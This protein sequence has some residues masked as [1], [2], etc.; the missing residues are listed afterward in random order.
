MKLNKESERSLREHLPRVLFDEAHQQ[1]WT[2]RNDLAIE[3]NRVNPT[4]STMLKAR[5]ELERAGFSIEINK[6]SLFTKELLKKYNA[7]FFAHNSDPKYEKTTG[8]GNAKLNKD[9]LAVIEEYVRNGGG[10]LILAEHE[11][12]KYNNSMSEMLEIFNIE[13]VNTTV[14]DPERSFNKVSSWVKPDLVNAGDGVLSRVNE[15]IFYRA[16]VVKVSDDESVCVKAKS[17]KSSDPK[18]EAMLVLKKFGAGR[19]A[20]VTDSDIFGDD[21]YQDGDHVQLLLNLM[22]WLVS[23]GGSE[24]VNKANELGE[25]WLSLKEEVNRFKN[26]QEKDGSVREEN[27]SE[28]KSSLDKILELYSNFLDVHPHNKD[29]YRKTVE[30]LNKWS[31][32][33]FGKPDFLD[34]LVSFRPDLRRENGLEH[35]VLSVMYTQ[36]GNPN[37]SLEALWIRTVWPDWINELEA[38]LYNNK[39]FIPVEFLDFS[40]G[41]E[42][43]SAVLFPETVPVREVPKFHWGAIF[44]DREAA[45]F[46]KIVSEA[47]K[48]LNFEVPTQVEMLLSNKN[49]AKEVY[50]LWDLVHDRTHSHGELP[51]DPFMIKQRIPFWMYALEEM[52]CDLNTFTEMDN[53]Y[54]KGVSHASYVKYAIILD[55]VLRFP[56][57]GNR[58]KNYDGLVGQIM[59]GA[60]HKAGALLWVD[61]KLRVNWER[62]ENVIT[63]LAKEVNSLY[64]ESID[65]SRIEFWIEGYK[66]VRKYVSPHPSSSWL[67]E[68]SFNK[69]NKELTDM[70]LA[71]EFPL[72]VFYE[73]LAKKLSKSIEEC[74]GIVL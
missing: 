32:E 57:S 47:S 49:F 28:A 60:L 31:K 15:L 61:N 37:R 10:L 33:G 30:D 43:H 7:L 71:D 59:F 17:S 23:T 70:V 50:V 8:A 29:Y 66:L 67:K 19:I 11:N 46:I 18:E 54:A 45:R 65:R 20:V 26:F 24:S 16:G 64:G 14:V 42:T 2:M 13:L 51:F 12:E 21:S 22:A 35:I 63:A 39:A 56:I 55:R 58:V 25:N 40:K 27:K 34:S 44:C 4:D 6:E 48:V 53:L 36:N 73:A 74:E 9:E 62:A 3:I 52:R 72:N 68:E 5:E 38:K 41:Y 69:S 1:A